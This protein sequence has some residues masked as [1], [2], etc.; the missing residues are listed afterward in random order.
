MHSGKYGL[1]ATV[2]GQEMNGQSNNYPSV[3]ENT[4]VKFVMH[5]SSKNAAMSKYDFDWGSFAQAGKT[6]LW[7]TTTGGNAT[8]DKLSNILTTWN[9]IYLGTRKGQSGYTQDGTLKSFKITYD[10]N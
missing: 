4:T 10:M 5:F 8:L 2:D 1:T 7:C 6:E 3:T 9:E